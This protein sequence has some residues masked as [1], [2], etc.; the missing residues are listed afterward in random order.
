M[1]HNKKMLYEQ[2]K[3]KFGGVDPNR[4]DEIISSKQMSQTPNIDGKKPVVPETDSEIL[5]LPFDLKY[6]YDKNYRYSYHEGNWYAKNINNNKIFNISKY[7]QFEDSVKNLNREFPNIIQP[8]TT[9]TTT[10]Q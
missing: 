2:G 10:S 9:T 7:P 3:P 8:T 5:K 1:P 6:P 4:E